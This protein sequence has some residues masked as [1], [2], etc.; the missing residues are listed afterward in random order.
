MNDPRIQTLEHLEITV[1]SEEV[2]HGHVL[3]IR[4][5]EV[6]LP[7]GGIRERE[8][9]EHPGGVLAVPILSDGR[10]I[11]IQQYRY[12]IDQPIYEFP[13]GKLEKGEPPLDCVQ[14][15]LEEETGYV[16]N[17]WDMLTQIVTSPG[18]CDEIIHLFVAQ[19]VER[20]PNPR[21]EEDEYIMFDA[22]S[23]DTIRQMI[24]DK[25]IIDA[26]TICAFSWVF[27]L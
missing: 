25:I 15:E 5:D 8:I 10:L 13:A 7:H 12:S 2:F 3:R 4:K 16:T 22:Y 14:R 18:F 26:K 11:L 1:S 17:N 19:D 9:V 6:R 23:P 24:R 27:G 21:R 20:S